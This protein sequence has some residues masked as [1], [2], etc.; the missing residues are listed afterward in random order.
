[1]TEDDHPITIAATADLHYD[2]SSKG[3]W[4]ELFV[5]ASRSADVLLICGDL[6]D[7]GLD[8]EAHLLADDLIAHCRIPVV[9]VLGNHDY[10]SN[11]VTEISKILEAA[12]VHLLSGSCVEIRGTGFVGT[13]GFGGGFGA[14]MLNAWGEPATK[15]FVQESVEQALHLER[16]LARLDT[17]Y[18][19][20]LLHYSPI[21]ETVMGENPEIFP[22][23]GSTRLEGPLNRFPVDAVFH[24]H[25]HNGAHEGRTSGGTPVYNV[26]ASVL[27]RLRPGQPPFVL[28]TPSRVSMGRET[29]VA[30]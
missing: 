21:R 20:A 13:H 30:I 6:T 14:R 22:F 5:Q 29:E 3:L 1:M 26:S 9:A 15:A 25:A 17:A 2:H 28:F 27:R 23:L 7:Y 18:K 19:I 8:E 11:R 24:G 4:K 16:A 10:E 12:G